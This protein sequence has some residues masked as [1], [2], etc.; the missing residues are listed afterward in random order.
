M[1]MNKT[2]YEGLRVRGFEGI[3]VSFLLIV[4]GVVARNLLL[5]LI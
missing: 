1:M 3:R 4:I 5:I 2:G